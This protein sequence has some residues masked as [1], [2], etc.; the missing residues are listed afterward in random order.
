MPA[1]PSVDS[2]LLE[3]LLTQEGR[4]TGVEWYATADLLLAHR[5]RGFAASLLSSIKLT[6]RIKV[7]DPG[8]CEKGILSALVMGMGGEGMLPPASVPGAPPWPIYTLHR[9]FSNQGVPSL[10]STIVVSGPVTIAYR[11]QVGRA[12][13]SPSEL[14]S[15]YGWQA[16]P[17]IPTV[18]D[19]LKYL[20]A[21]LSL[22]NAP[23]EIEYR[24]VPWMGTDN[25]IT[26]TARLRENIRQKHT[27]LVQLL[28]ANGL[29]SAQEAADVPE[30]SIE[31]TV[32]DVR[33]AK[34]PLPDVQNH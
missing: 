14:Q 22:T 15:S 5:A 31:I 11:R 30:P 7:C 17:R 9:V 20:S 16:E 21:L 12:G 8:D 10:S 34:T 3:L 33:A 19:R 27:T 23:D 1:S 6:G 24:S 25:F 29:L 4:G 13:F 2:A 18:A 28:R 26:E 32:S